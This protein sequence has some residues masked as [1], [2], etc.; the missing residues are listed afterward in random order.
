[1]NSAIHIWQVTHLKNKLPLFTSDQ[2]QFVK[3]TQYTSNSITLE[4]QDAF[5]GKGQLVSVG[6]EMIIGHEKFKFEALAELVQNEVISDSLVQFEFKIYQNDQVL[7]KKFIDS[8]TTAQNHVDNLMLR[9]K[10]ES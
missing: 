9:M 2:G 10:G 6:G 8:K 7:W 4:L 3:V 1:M 5:I